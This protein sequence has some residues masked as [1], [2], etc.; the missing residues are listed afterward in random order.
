MLLFLPF[1]CFPCDHCNVLLNVSPNDFRNS[2]DLMFRSREM[3]G[4]YNYFGEMI[5]TRHAGH[6]NDIALWGQDVRETYQ[7]IELR[8]NFYFFDKWRTT[9]VL[10]FVNNVQRLNES[11]RYRINAPGDPMI[12][13][14]YR[15]YNT[16]G[17]TV[18]QGF[19]QRWIIGGGLRFPL[20]K[21]DLSFDNGVP[22]LDLQP[23]KGS[24]GSLF[25]ATFTFKYKW[26]GLRNNF[27]F[28]HNGQDQLRYQYGQTLNWISQLF[29]DI[30][31]G[32]NTLRL[33]AGTYFEKAKID[34]TRSAG[35]EPGILHN[36]TGGS[37]WFM[38]SGLRFFTKD[39][40]FF[41]TYEHAISSTL[42]GYEQLLTKGMF[43]TGLTW[44]FNQ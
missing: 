43:N 36:N 44:Y 35:N 39:V 32:N 13:Q 20:G 6:G 11:V 25:F 8:G 22:N 27:S 18:D 41:C 19:T 37:I 42:N 40:Q 29:S 5:T 28:L 24:F 15:L 16:M 33:Q 12:L 1:T 3:F 30:Q 14:S 23:G 26:I 9:F 17:D 31:I 7:T 2:I 21:T 10:P 4:T 38:Q 34:R